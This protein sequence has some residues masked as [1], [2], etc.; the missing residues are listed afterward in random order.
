MIPV[1]CE[2]F[3][4]PDFGAAGDRGHLAAARELAVEVREQRHA[5]IESQ[6]CAGIEA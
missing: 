6:R 5:L 3:S 1:L 2:H 4:P